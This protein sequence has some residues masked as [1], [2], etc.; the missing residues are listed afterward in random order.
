MHEAVINAWREAEGRRQLE[1]PESHATRLSAAPLNC[2][3]ELHHVPLM[4]IFLD[5]S[6]GHSC[7]PSLHLILT[8]SLHLQSASLMDCMLD[9]MMVAQASS[10]K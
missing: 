4:Q 2:T 1:S 3:I 8:S 9:S 7:L 10:A 6:G 5:Q